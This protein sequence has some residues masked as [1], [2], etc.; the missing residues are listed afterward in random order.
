MPMTIDGD[1]SITGLSAGGLPDNSITA[2]ELADGI[3]TRAKVSTSEADSFAF[4]RAWVNF[5]GTGTVAIRADFNVSSITDNNTGD[6]TVNF[7]NALPDGNYSLTGSAGD[8]SVSTNS[9]PGIRPAAAFATGSVRFTVIF[10]S[11]ATSNVG[12]YTQVSVAI[13]R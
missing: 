12:D 6:Y 13:F 9:L 4:C 2:A 11:G 5:N 1:G 8:T 7:S 3:I 10:A